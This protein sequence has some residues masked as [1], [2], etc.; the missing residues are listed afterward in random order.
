[1]DTVRYKLVLDSRDAGGDSD[2]LALIAPN[3]RH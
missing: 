1:M 3:R 2:G